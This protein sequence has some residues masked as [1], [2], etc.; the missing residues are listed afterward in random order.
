MSNTVKPKTPTPPSPF[1][2]LQRKAWCVTSQKLVHDTYEKKQT[3]KTETGLV[4]LWVTRDRNH[5]LPLPFGIFFTFLSQNICCFS[6]LSRTLFIISNQKLLHQALKSINKF[7]S[8]YFLKCLLEKTKRVF[9]L[10]RQLSPR[11]TISLLLPRASFG[12]SALRPCCSGLLRF[13][14]ACSP[15]FHGS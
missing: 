8:T 13:R 12:P 4:N 2:W 14:L 10:K 1:F 11:K 9:T 15:R 7:I 3:N 6:V 5:P